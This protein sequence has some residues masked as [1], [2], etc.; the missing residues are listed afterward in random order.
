MIIPI[1]NKLLDDFALKNHEY[2]HELNFYDLMSGQQEYRLYSY[3]STLFNNVTIL[4][5]GTHKG[6]S[7]VSLS[8]ND[9]NQVLS[10]D[11]HD[12]INDPT[13]K[14]YSKENIKFF[15]KNVLDDLNEEMIKSVKIVMIDIDHFE[16]VEE[17][18]I[19]RLRDIK[20]SGIILL[21]DTTGH[22][23]P[24]INACMKRLWGNIKEQK[25]D[26]TQYGHCTGTGVVIMND[27]IQFSFDS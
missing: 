13:H 27:D 19:Q 26:F 9:T 22:A 11:I 8:H 23:D 14:V 21:D 20:F 10:Y 5:I 7:A 1:S 6:R 16:T 17:K 25:Y 24:T 2:L 12:W 3:L 4:D 15:V 18:I